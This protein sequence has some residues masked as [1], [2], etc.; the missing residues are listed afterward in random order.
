[1]YIEL[2]S[3]NGLLF[4]DI[5]QFNS[6]IFFSQ[7]DS[8]IILPREFFNC[9]TLIEIS[10]VCINKAYVNGYVK[11]L[12]KLHKLSLLEIPNA[13]LE[14]FFDIL[15]NI[16]VLNITLEDDVIYDIMNIGL[17]TNIYYDKHCGW[18]TYRSP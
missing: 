4:A 14:H 11:N 3:F 6:I 15:K 1:M 5:D 10:L 2:E 9:V 16:N 18:V 13:L 17:F 7:S 12:V 8:E